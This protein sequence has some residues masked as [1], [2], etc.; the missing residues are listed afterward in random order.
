LIEEDKKQ[1]DIKSGQPPE[2]IRQVTW[3]PVS[4]EE[5]DV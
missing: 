3:L 2:T 4:Q 1:G 5:L